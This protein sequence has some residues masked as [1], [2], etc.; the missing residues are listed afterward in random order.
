MV[1]YSD[2]SG[3]LC[4]MPDDERC[5]H[6][7]SYESTLKM[8]TDNFLRHYDSNRAPFPIFIH[9]YFFDN[10]DYTLKAIAKFLDKVETYELCRTVDQLVLASQG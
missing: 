3:G 1:D 10:H 4:A 8:L 7:G 5:D 2:V 9:S 6:G